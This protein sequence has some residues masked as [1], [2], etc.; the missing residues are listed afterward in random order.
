M[1]TSHGFL[2][3]N[4]DLLLTNRFI[5]VSIKEDFVAKSFRFLWQTGQVLMDL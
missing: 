5:L 1:I 3:F 4:D 2:A